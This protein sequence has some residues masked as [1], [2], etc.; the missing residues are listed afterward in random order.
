MLAKT[1][2]DKMADLSPAE[3][4]IARAMLA[5]YPGAGLGSVQMLA[6]R[7]GV[8]LPSVVRFARRLGFGGFVE[9][10]QELRD[11]ISRQAK[12]PLQRLENWHAADTPPALIETAIRAS[13]MAIQASLQAIPE[14][15]FTES[16]RL[17]SAREHRIV[18]G[19]GRISQSLAVYFGRNL[20]QVRRKVDVLSENHHE[21]IQQVIDTGKNDVFV[22]FDFRR[23][24][25][26]I[27]QL[28]QEVVARGAT[29]IVV[30]DVQLSPAASLASVVLPLHVEMPWL[31]DG[32][33][34]GT[35]L[36]DALIAGVMENQGEKTV[37]RLRQWEALGPLS[38]NAK[39]K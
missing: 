1:I 31:F 16:L 35:V 4:K 2:K 36:I 28:A 30:T 3:R 25:Q 13:T 27:Y 34:A 14:Y 19:G 23:Y 33:A 10:Q 22:L 24:Q 8:S 21:R 32:Y 9:F 20:Q 26:D 38:L 29:L 17:L 37:D 6:E 15:D 11:E 12:G 18:L 39:S 5:D 7:S